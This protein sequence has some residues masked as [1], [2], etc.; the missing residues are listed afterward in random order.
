MGTKSL[1]FLV[2][3]KGR[4]RLKV[5]LASVTMGLADLVTAARSLA[6]MGRSSGL[7]QEPRTSEKMKGVMLT[8]RRARVTSGSPGVWAD[9]SVTIWS[10]SDWV[11]AESCAGGGVRT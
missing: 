10:I 5:S 8:S 2:I 1:V 3:S 6:V 4:L 7:N 9:W 11:W